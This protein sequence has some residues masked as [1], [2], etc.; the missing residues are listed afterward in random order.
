MIFQNKSVQTWRII[1]KIILVSSV[2]PSWNPAS[3][4]Q[5]VDRYNTM[6]VFFLR[7]RGGGE[8]IYQGNEAIR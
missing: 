7:E 5:A 1:K 8:A 6:K 4:A 3:D 2:D